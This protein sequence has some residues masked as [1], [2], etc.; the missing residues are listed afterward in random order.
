MAD[1]LVAFDWTCDDGGANVVFYGQLKSAKKLK[2]LIDFATPKFLDNKITISGCTGC[3]L[4]SASE[5]WW[6]NDVVDLPDNSVSAAAIDLDGTD[7]DG[8]GNDDIFNEGTIF[9]LGATRDTYGYTLGRDKLA[10][11]L[12]DAVVLDKVGNIDGPDCGTNSIN[13]R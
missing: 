6:S 10:I 1:D 8:G 9:T 3:P 13:R 12:D 2:D 5:S 11:V 4:T 7:D